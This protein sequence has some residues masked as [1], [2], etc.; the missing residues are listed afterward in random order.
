MNPIRRW[1]EWLTTNQTRKLIRILG[2][3]IM[4]AQSD[5]AERVK[6]LTAKV[7]DLDVKIQALVTAAAN[8]NNIDPA[9]KQA[10]DDLEAAIAK[11]DAD[12]TPAP[13]AP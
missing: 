7:N 3:R 11:D 8:Q 10:V 9:L 2:G 12:A 6:G 5:L 1:W 13:P 4:S